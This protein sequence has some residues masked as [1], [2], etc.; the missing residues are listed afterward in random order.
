MCKAS[1]TY[2][3]IL[4]CEIVCTCWV[5]CFAEI[6]TLKLQPIGKTCLDIKSVPSIQGH[7][8]WEQTNI[9]SSSAKAEG[10]QG[11]L[12]CYNVTTPSFNVWALPES[13]FD[14]GHRFHLQLTIPNASQASKAADLQ[15]RT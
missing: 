14:K 8:S 5:H 6:L 11:L 10:L 13:A 7:V 2:S 9:F 3:N 1:S 4:I 15:I 12:M